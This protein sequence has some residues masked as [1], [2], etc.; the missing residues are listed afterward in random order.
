MIKDKNFQLYWE[1]K[2]K[3]GMQRAYGSLKYN[4]CLFFF[5][6]NE[7]RGGMYLIR[8][9]VNLL[10]ENGKTLH[11]TGAHRR[12]VMAEIKQRNGG[13]LPENYKDLD[14]LRAKKMVQLR[15]MEEDDI[16]ARVKAAAEDLYTENFS[17]IQDDRKASPVDRL[18]PS[19]AVQRY[20]KR[21]LDNSRNKISRER[22]RRK[23]RALE[24]ISSKLDRCTMD[25][26]SERALRKV[27]EELGDKAKEAFRLAEEFWR[28]CTEIGVYRGMNP[29][30][31]Y[32]L[33]HPISTRKESEVLIRQMLTPR[34]LPKRVEKNLRLEIQKA[35][36]DDPR[37][38]GILLA[39][40][41]GFSADEA[42]TLRW[43]DL[44][45]NQMGRPET[46]V[47]FAIQKEF[48]AGATHDYT[49]PC[50][51][52]G[53][54]ELYRRMEACEKKWGNLKEHYV[55]EDSKGNRLTSKKLTEFCR[56][57]LLHCGMAHS[58]LSPDHSQPYGVGIRLLLSHYKYR[59]TY[60]AG[61]R[62]D[63]GV[64]RFLQGLSLAGDVSSDH[65]R[66]FTSPEG[67]DFLLNVL[68]RDKSFEEA[69]PA[70]KA[71]QCST[72]GQITSVTVLAQ[73]PDHF[74]VAT[75]V[76]RLEKGQY[77]DLSSMN[78][79][80]GQIDIRKIEEP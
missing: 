69:L 13:E 19:E 18:H 47:Q 75:G 1:T 41:G 45:F 65:Y 21:F 37:Y 48:T 52:F 73:K 28:F 49:R 26:I 70:D 36:P 68:S 38:T 76:I 9:S 40:E 80:Y 2:E 16:Y 58:D 62:A 66:S 54:R 5:S 7:Q 56:E 57:R 63:C 32:R 46:T 30:E 35:K 79:G 77:L 31:Q 42:C 12:E 59:I 53:A 67:Q 6:L 72:D 78:L 43:D 14:S 3:T 23:E 51:P 10:G 55:L 64:V 71:V 74:N 15:S 4:G 8:G 22:R 11:I 60:L 61:L 29:F 27:S 39:M 25:N 34:S 24:R 50:T 44:R 17:A 33:K 20:K